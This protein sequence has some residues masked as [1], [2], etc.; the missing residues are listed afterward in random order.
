MNRNVSLRV[1][2]RD[3][4]TIEL[5]ELINEPDFRDN[6]QSAVEAPNS[7]EALNIKKKFLPLIKIL[8]SKI[9]WSPFE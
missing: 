2:R 6:L 8:G 5:M 7:E 4:R 1:D 3:E 9:K